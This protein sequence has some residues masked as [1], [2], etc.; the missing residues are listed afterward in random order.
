M[1]IGNAAPD[2]DGRQGRIGGTEGLVPS[3]CGAGD[4]RETRVQPRACAEMLH[5]LVRPAPHPE[6]TRPPVP[7][8]LPH[9]SANWPPSTT[10]DSPV[11]KLASSEARK[12]KT[13][14]T[15]LPGGGG[16]LPCRWRPGRIELDLVVQLGG[17][18][19]G[20]DAVDPDAVLGQLDRHRL[21]QEDDAGLRGVEAGPPLAKV[22]IGRGHVDDRPAGALGHHP[23]RRQLSQ[24]EAGR[25]VDRQG[26]LPGHQ[27]LLQEGLGHGDPG[28]VD[29]DVEPAQPVHR[30]LNQRFPKRLIGHVADQT[31]DL[32]AG[33]QVGD[34]LFQPVRHEIADDEAGALGQKLSGDRLADA[35]S[36]A[37]D[38]CP[39]SRQ[40]RHCSSPKKHR[41][42]CRPATSD[43]AVTSR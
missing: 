36:R 10:T 35:A 5:R 27:R 6:G 18:P 39:L 40:S 11:T 25:Q 16:F 28:V 7:P 32:A 26:P 33:S 30:R 24:G 22:A 38:D 17:D 29:Q 1:A 42:R 4:E 19:A 14:A 13:L 2:R 12:A 9:S 37:G 20:R 8:A 3:G 43:D 15:S 41:R 31:V 34:G 23:P 21:G